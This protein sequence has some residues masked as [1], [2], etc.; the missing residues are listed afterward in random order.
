MTR[1]YRAAD[2]CER[3]SIGRRIAPEHD[4]IRIHAGRYAAAP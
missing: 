3:S 4:E 1:S 2:V